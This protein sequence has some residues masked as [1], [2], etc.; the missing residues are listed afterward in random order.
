MRKWKLFEE[1]CYLEIFG[2]NPLQALQGV[3]FLPRP[4]HLKSIF[5]TNKKDSFVYVKT[6]NLLINIACGYINTIH[7][8]RC[9]FDFVRVEV[10]TNEGV[11]EID[12]RELPN[13]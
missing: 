6:P 7:N 8:Q 5:E 4:D 10:S 1:Y 11:K 12:M 13:G 9:G 3:S 2:D